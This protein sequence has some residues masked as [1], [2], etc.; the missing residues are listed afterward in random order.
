MLKLN[1]DDTDSVIRKY[2]RRFQ[3]INYHLGQYKNVVY[4]QLKN[5]RTNS[6]KGYVMGLKKSL[7]KNKNKQTEKN[8]TL[9]YQTSNFG[10]VQLQSIDS[11][12]QGDANVAPKLLFSD[13]Y[14]D[15]TRSNNS[16]RIQYAGQS[17]VMGHWDKMYTFGIP[18]LFNNDLHNPLQK[19]IVFISLIGLYRCWTLIAPELL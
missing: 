14:K 5:D 11:Q 16:K 6:I 15:K 1:H 17:D 19:R 10:R 2:K 9:F 4:V 12:F 3:N 18:T 13:N 7:T 8:G